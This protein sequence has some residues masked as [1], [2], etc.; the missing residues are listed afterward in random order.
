MKK[1]PT[2]KDIAK[3]ANV[4]ATAV[5]M[6]LNNRS[7]VSAKTRKKILK[8]ANK[9]EYQ[10]NFIAK[11]LI[12]KRSYTIGFILNSITDPFFPELA[13]GIEECANQRGYNLLLCNT[14]RSLEMEKKSIDVLRS[15][16]VDGIILATVWK[17]DPNIPPL[18]EEG[19]P[20]VLINRISMDPA[21]K[22]K[23]N[24][25]VI[26]NYRGGYEGMQHLYRLGHDRIAVITGDLNTST[27]ILRTDGAIKAL[28]D[29][30][31]NVDRDLIVEGQYK[32]DVA[33][34]QAKRLISIE[35][36]PTAYFAQDDYMAVGIREAL[37]EAGLRVPANIAL[38]SFDDTIIASLSGID[39]TTIS[40]NKYEMGAMGTN[41]LIEKI[42]N[43][44][45]GVVSQL[46]LEAGLT[47]RKSCGHHQTGYVRPALLQPNQG[48]IAPDSG[49]LP[50][51]GSFA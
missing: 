11:S 10:P 24:F 8:I 34:N 5:S 32:R 16:G 35:N 4:S 27:A 40:Q 3:L 9:L 47:I 1:K 30:G 45:S 39:M 23:T 7:G 20:F 42:E 12:S 33:Y 18:I 6:A 19:F 44:S 29:Y 43:R 21:I 31:V 17:D 49:T 26:D 51:I 38:V 41:I 28:Q 36:P 13:K 37:Y 50:K 2:I 22:N 14:K 48:V 15:K 46:I 25:V